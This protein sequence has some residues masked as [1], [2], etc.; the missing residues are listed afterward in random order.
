MILIK[1]PPKLNRKL[2]GFRMKEYCALPIIIYIDKN[3]LKLD[4]NFKL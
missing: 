3:F 1:K 4:M 2:R